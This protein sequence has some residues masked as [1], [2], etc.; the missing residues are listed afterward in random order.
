MRNLLCVLFVSV[1]LMWPNAVQAADLVNINVLRQEDGTTWGELWYK[2][3]M[4]WRL[5]ILA[6]GAKP[7]AGFHSARTTFI[8]PDLVDG[9]FLI[10]VE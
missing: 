6:D 8:A 10:K 7:V 9:F 1:V 2:N 5:A 4:V 3:Q